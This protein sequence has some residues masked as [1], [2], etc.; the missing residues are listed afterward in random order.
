MLGLKVPSISQVL[1]TLLI[2]AIASFAMK[3]LPIPDS[4]K[5]LFR[6]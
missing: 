3:I 4:V 2:L 6:F 5:N 1:N